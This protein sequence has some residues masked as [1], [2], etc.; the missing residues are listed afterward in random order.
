MTPK[1]VKPSFCRVYRGFRDASDLRI[2]NVDT[3][4]TGPNVEGVY[5][6]VLNNMVSM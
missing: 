6:G 4:D 2:F 3:G 5:R 1:I